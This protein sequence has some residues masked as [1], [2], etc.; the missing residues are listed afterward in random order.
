MRALLC[1]FVLLLGL[2]PI[3]VAT[4]D[5]HR[6]SSL[7]P[8]SF[9]STT[10]E[11]LEEPEEWV[12]EAWV[13]HSRDLVVLDEVSGVIT[14][15]AV[16]TLDY[17][18]EPFPGCEAESPLM[19]ENGVFSQW[20]T[21]VI[22]DE[23]GTWDGDVFGVEVWAEGE[24]VFAVHKLVL[25]G[26]GGNAGKSIV[27]DIN[28]AED[29]EDPTAYLEGV[30]LT[31]GVPAFGVNMHTQLCAT[32]SNLAQGAFVST[33]A[34]ESSGAVSAGMFAAG[35]RWTHTYSLLGELTFTDD[36]GS[37]SITFLG[38]SQDTAE[39]SVDWG[40]W[41][42]TGGTGFYENAFGHGKATGYYGYFEQCGGDG[43]W[44]QFL[45]SV[46]FN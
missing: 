23:A 31:M 11:V 29:P 38:T 27:A 9:S 34:I 24:L 5:N 46:H 18:A 37:L 1:A 2:A 44:L 13:Y 10:V 28:F 3:G 40:H 20:G 35:S 42:I 45:G 4:A 43:E 17:D 22:T 33:G 6:T 21:V 41:V 14:G 16:L 8:I 12:D 36:V 25:Q 15:T 30:M 32:D 19:C 26:R 39:S 7:T